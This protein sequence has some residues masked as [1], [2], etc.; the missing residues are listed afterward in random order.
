MHGHYY[1][2]AIQRRVRADPA[3][4]TRNLHCACAS[5]ALPVAR[6]HRRRCLWSRDSVDMTSTRTW[7]RQSGAWSRS[8]RSCRWQDSYSSWH[9]RGSAPARGR[10]RTSD[11]PAAHRS[12]RSA[13]GCVV[14]AS[15]RQTPPP[16]RPGHGSR[17]TLFDLRLSMRDATTATERWRRRRRRRLWETTLDERRRQRWRNGDRDC[18]DGAAG[19]SRCWRWLSAVRHTP[20]RRTQ[21]RCASLVSRLRCRSICTS[22]HAKNCTKFGEQFT[23]VVK[24]SFGN[25]FTAS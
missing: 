6:V 25:N 8:W 7:R 10:S 19:W 21:W 20:A 12:T 4:P 1:A 14:E 24:E 17:A 13:G 3:P 15:R 11:G 5:A 9:M 23:E 22:S 16:P 2:A 18:V